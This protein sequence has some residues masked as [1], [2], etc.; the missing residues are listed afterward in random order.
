M[1]Y[2]HIWNKD[3]KLPLL[4][5]HKI[6]LKGN[7]KTL[8]SLGSEDLNIYKNKTEELTCRMDS[9]IRTSVRLAYKAKEIFS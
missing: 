2:R 6:F 5:T 4:C 3:R 1:L 8:I 9:P 7:L